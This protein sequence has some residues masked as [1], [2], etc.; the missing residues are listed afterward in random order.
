MTGDGR[1]RIV[2]SGLSI[3]AIIRYIAK[4]RVLKKILLL[5]IELNMSSHQSPAEKNRNAVAK[6][7]EAHKDDVLKRKAEARLAKGLGIT[8]ATAEKFGLE[9]PSKPEDP[10]VVKMQTWMNDNKTA[11]TAKMYGS[12]LKRAITGADSD[13][14]ADLRKW[15]GLNVANPN[16]QRTALQALLCYSGEDADVLAAYQA[17]DEAASEYNIQRSFEEEVMPFN[18]IKEKV[19]EHFPEGSDQGLYMDLY[20]LIP[21]RDDL[22]NVELCSKDHKPESENWLRTDTR[23]LHIGRHKTVGKYGSI[24][25]KLPKKLMDLIPTDRKYL[26]EKSEGKA[27]GSMSKFVGDMLK[28]CGAHNKGSINYLRHSYASTELSGSKI[29]DT[30]KRRELFVKMLHS[31]LTQLKYLRALESTA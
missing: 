31:P 24:H 17:A 19:F 23:E 2:E 6:H 11:S 26:F 28:T 27:F 5:I 9:M 14:V 1:V 4:K 16:T 15:I 22:G 10:R 12:Q 25:V 8:K 13:V 3:M 18:I 30:E 20:E 7:Y 21:T 29:K